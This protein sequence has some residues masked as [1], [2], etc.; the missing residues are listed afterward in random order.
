MVQPI[1]TVKDAAKEV[2]GEFANCENSD[3]KAIILSNAKNK[4]NDINEKFK[5]CC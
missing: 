5:D 1:H 2:I 4:N 3:M